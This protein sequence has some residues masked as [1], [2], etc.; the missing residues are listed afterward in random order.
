MLTKEQ[1]IK[2]IKNKIKKESQESREKIPQE[3]GNKLTYKQKWYLKNK[4]KVKDY[5]KKY[6]SK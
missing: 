6:Y 3:G 2:I 5:N 1:I 4:E